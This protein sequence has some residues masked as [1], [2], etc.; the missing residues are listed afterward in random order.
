MELAKGVH[1][2][3]TYAN[4]ALYTDGRLVLVDT[5]DDDDAKD[6]FAYL[7]KVGHVP[8]DIT[9]IFV[10][11]THPDHVA[12]LATVKE[13]APDAKIAV[14]RDDA[15]YVARAKTYPGPPGPQSHRPV[16]V[17]LLLEDGQ[18]HDG[19]M[20][21]HTPGHTPGSMALLDTERGILIAG[22]SLENGDELSPLP[23]RVNIDP[24]QHRQSIKKLAN[25][26][27]ETILFGHGEP[28]LEGGRAQVRALADRL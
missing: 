14:H 15:D 20:V 23:D 8:K 18:T 1:M 19:L 26:E 27:Y 7:M 24:R 28:I 3:E 17:D 10:T 5:S 6:I 11:H 22:D 9:T 13:Q 21:I 2:I 16:P 12:G 25:Y 4:C